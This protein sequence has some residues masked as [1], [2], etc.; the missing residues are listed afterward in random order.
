MVPFLDEGTAIRDYLFERTGQ[1]TVP[2][3]Y[4]KGTHLGGCDNTIAAH[5]EGRLHKLLNP[6]EKPVE[7]NFDYDLIVIGG[8]SGGLACSKAAAELGAKVAV[9]DFVKPTPIGTTWGKSNSLTEKQ[10]RFNNTKYLVRVGKVWEVL[11]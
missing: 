7:E 10:L 2:N 4:V 6:E 3:V 9:L 1:K 5:T 8:G 11:A